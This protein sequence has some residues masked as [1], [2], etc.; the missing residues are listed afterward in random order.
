M[1]N[2]LDYHEHGTEKLN[3]IYFP[4]AEAVAWICITFDWIVREQLVAFGYL[5]YSLLQEI[6]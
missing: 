1:L 4:G 2:F 6:A 5:L 3:C